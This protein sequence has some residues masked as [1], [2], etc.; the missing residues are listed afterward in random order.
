MRDYLTAIL[1]LVAVTLSIAVAFTWMPPPKG[2]WIDC[3]M[4]E[5]SPDFSPEMRE[6][7]RKLRRDNLQLGK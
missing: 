7:C 3:R 1:C 5:I 2:V 6:A 4:S